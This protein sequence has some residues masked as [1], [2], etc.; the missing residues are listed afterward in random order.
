MHLE[1]CDDMARGDIQFAGL[2]RLIT[3]AGKLCLVPTD[4]RQLC[5]EL[6]LL[7][8]HSLLVRPDADAFRRQTFPRE[9]RARVK[10]AQRRDVAMANDVARADVVT[11]ADVL[12]QDDQGLHLRFAVGIPETAGRGVLETRIDDLDA[13]GAGVQPGPALPLAFSGV[14]GPQVFIH[15]F[16][17]GRVFVVTDQVMAAD[18]AMGQQLQRTLQRGG[19]VMHHHELDTAV[20]IGGRVTGVVARTTGTTGQEHQRHDESKKFHGRSN[21]RKTVMQQCNVLPCVRRAIARF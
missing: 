10:L 5:I 11:L 7:A 15:Q 8:G 13:D 21:T 1:R 14:P 6:S 18:F 3:E 17:D 19:G 20:V 9:Q 16:V 12:E 4:A 2:R